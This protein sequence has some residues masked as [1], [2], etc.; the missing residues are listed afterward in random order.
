MKVAVMGA[1][2]VG[3]YF[4]GVL[5][6]NGADITLIARGKHLEAMRK[7]GLHI[8]SYRGDFRVDVRAASDPEE[9]G[10]VELIIFT[11]KAYDTEGA[12]GLC[13][14]MIQKNTCILSL[15]NGIDNDEKIAG[16]VGWEKVIGGVAYIGVSVE[17]PGVICHSAAGKIALGEVDRKITHRIRR[18]AEMFSSAG[19]PC[20]ISEDIIKLKW[21]KLVWNAAFN[22]LTT[23]TRA[24]VAEVLSDAKLMEIAVA[25]MHEVIEVAQK[26]GIDIDE[27]AIQDALTLSKNVGDFKTSMLQDF[28]SGR[29][30][31]VEALNGIVLRKGREA[32]VKTP[33]NQCL[34]SLV[35][36]MEKKR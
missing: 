5:A 26:K 30:T 14:P 1:G 34:Y 2:A 22:A 18:I 8:K 10:P 16:A 21:K 11:V 3:G 9:V 32:N 17:E 20:E 27:A 29:K 25:A 15:Q 19:V 24:S 35:S 12:I 6:K 36:F 28:E 33:V 7:E 4:G 23:I 31:E 13:S